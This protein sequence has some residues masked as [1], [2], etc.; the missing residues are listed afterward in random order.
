MTRLIHNEGFNFQLPK[1]H[2]GHPTLNSQNPREK[3]QSFLLNNDV[4]VF[5]G[6]PSESSMRSRIFPKGD[7]GGK[8]SWSTPEENG[9]FVLFLEWKA[10]T[11]KF[12]EIRV[13]ILW[14]VFFVINVGEY[15]MYGSDVSW[16]QDN[17]DDQKTCATPDIFLWKKLKRSTQTHPWNSKQPV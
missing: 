5:C 2:M 12:A 7:W 13:G 3:F 1:Y 10:K 9:V 11:R 4:F 14:L 6:G 16:I 17:K 15:T 8:P